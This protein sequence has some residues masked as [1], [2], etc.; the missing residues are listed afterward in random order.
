MSSRTLARYAKEGT[1]V[2][3]TTLPK[4]HRRWDLDDLRRQLAALNRER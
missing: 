4:G 2:P 3:A 1:L